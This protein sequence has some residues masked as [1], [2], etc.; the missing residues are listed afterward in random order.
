MVMKFFNGIIFTTLLF[1][2]CMSKATE[3]T[4][5][6]NEQFGQNNVELKAVNKQVV[7]G[8]LS[9]ANIVTIV[10]SSIALICMLIVVITTHKYAPFSK[11]KPGG[12]HGLNRGGTI[13][14]GETESLVRDNKNDYQTTT[15]IIVTDVPVQQI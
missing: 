2:F 7:E 6:Q 8:A 12:R 11:C 10:S 14:S 13:N 15:T 5:I 3:N 1:V 9:A 4:K